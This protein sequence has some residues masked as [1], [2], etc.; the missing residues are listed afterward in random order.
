MIESSSVLLKE[1]AEAIYQRLVGFYGVP[2]WRGPQQPMDELIST[3][4]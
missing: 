2:D 1:K 4:L 3:I